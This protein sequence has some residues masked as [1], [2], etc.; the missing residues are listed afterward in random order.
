MTLST[1]LWRPMSSRAATSVPSASNSPAAWSPP[2]RPKTRC[3]ERSFPGRS[4]R[5]SG[6]VLSASFGLR[7]PRARSESIDARPQMPQ[8]EAATK[9][10]WRAPMSTLRSGRRSTSTTF[11]RGAPVGR[12]S[13]RDPQDVA[14][15]L[16]DAFGVEPPRRKLEVVSR[17]PH[18]DRERRPADADFER[19][20][21]GEIVLNAALASFIPLDDVGRLDALRGMSHV[22]E[23]QA[24]SSD[25]QPMEAVILPSLDY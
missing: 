16:D 8:L 5:N 15:P 4:V 9:C 18:R 14:A 6:V 7:V 21:S 19:F 25:R 17:R 10:L 13:V 20:F 23:R 22:L 11:A 24:K 2:V 3:A 12:S 1:A